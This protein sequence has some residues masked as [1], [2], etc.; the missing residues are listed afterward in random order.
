[1][2]IVRFSRSRK[3]KYYIKFEINRQTSLRKNVQKR[4]TAVAAL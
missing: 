3:N 4:E 2:S 1:M